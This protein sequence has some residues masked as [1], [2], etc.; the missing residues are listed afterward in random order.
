MYDFI[1]KSNPGRL[2]CHDD[3]PIYDQIEKAIKILRSKNLTS[4]R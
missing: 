1:D 2:K 3:G 4:I